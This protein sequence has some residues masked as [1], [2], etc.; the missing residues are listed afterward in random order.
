MGPFSGMRY[1]GSLWDVSVTDYTAQR[2]VSQFESQPHPQHSCS[3]DS[4]L[5]D[6]RI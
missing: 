1:L 5:I 3:E 6:S 2:D 4:E